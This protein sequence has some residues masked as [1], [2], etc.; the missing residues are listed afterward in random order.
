M[1]VVSMSAFHALGRWLAPGTVIPKTIINWYKLPP[2][3]G[4]RVLG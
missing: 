4:T 2:L 3:H 1:T